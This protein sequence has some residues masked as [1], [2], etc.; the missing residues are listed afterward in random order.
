LLSLIDFRG[1]GDAAGCA[2]GAGGVR[3][4]LGLFDDFFEGLVIGFVAEFLLNFGILLTMHSLKV[5]CVAI[6]LTGV[7]SE[8]TR[9]AI[10]F[11]D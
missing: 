8:L 1:G 5:D 10:F 4:L 3:L 11:F 2:I 9:A 7:L 6:F